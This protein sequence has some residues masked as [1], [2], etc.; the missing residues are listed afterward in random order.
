M[1]GTMYAGV[2]TH[3]QTALPTAII[4][5]NTLYTTGADITAPA[6]YVQGWAEPFQPGPSLVSVNFDNVFVDTSTSSQVKWEA[7]LVVVW[8]IRQAPFGEV[9]AR[10]VDAVIYMW[11]QSP[12]FGGACDLSDPPELAITPP[13]DMGKD[14]GLVIATWRIKKGGH[15]G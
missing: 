7:E 6:R 14:T 15:Y 12:T 10:A 9:Q 5:I 8:T 4:A 11:Q 1:I 2:F 13:S 3:I